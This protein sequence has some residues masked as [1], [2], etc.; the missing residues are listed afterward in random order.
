MDRNIRF[1]ELEVRLLKAQ[2]RAERASCD[3]AEA[4]D[5]VPSGIPYPDSVTRIH[6]AAREYR[7]AMAEFESASRERNQFLLDEPAA[8][9]LPS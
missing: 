6:V 5:Y 3:F 9:S 2:R 1:H 7:S 8:S 4:T